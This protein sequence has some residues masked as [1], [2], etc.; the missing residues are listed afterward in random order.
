L[1]TRIQ[2]SDLVHAR[3]S[4]GTA[5]LRGGV[6]RGCCIV[7]ALSGA[8][9]KYAIFALVH[10]SPKMGLI[11]LIAAL[12]LEQWRPLSERRY[13]ISQVGRYAGFLERQFNAGETQHGLVAWLVAVL[14]PVLL[15]WIAYVLMFRWSPPLALA[16]NVVALY[17][18]MGFRQSSHYFT[19]IHLALKRD[20]LDRARE[21]LAAWRGHG[22]AELSR[23]EVA[24][25]TIE[26]ALVA[27][28]R[29]VFAVVFWFVLLP[30]PTGAILYR[31]A[32]FLRRRWGDRDNP[33]L[34]QFG[35]FAIGAFD[36]LD[37]LPVRFTATAFAVVGDFEDA[38]FCW[39][40]QA[41]RWSD[42]AMGIVLAAGA[43][44]VGVR[45]GNPIVINGSIIERTE[46]GLGEAADIAF[47]DSTVGLVWRALVLWL[48]MLL[49]LGVARAVS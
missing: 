46:L 17:F 48:L 4:P 18:T 21:R 36:T 32:A 39:R 29:N 10:S 41:A 27:S 31:L 6:S 23:E 43:G 9:A 7:A 26:E 24:R 40:T 14:P 15:T 5:H 45:L 13:L 12:L 33:E 11:S 3:R 20:D 47:F 42:A 34:A 37:Y 8:R 49:L 30:G 38:I 22:C 16:F 44:A 2:A 1:R 19:D 25:L 35:R 28:H